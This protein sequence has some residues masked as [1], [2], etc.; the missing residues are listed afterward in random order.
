MASASPNPSWSDD[1]GQSDQYEDL[2]GLVL[3]RLSG[4]AN[5]LVEGVR[6]QPI[7]A[8]AIIA[9]GVGVLIGVGLARRHEDRA[10]EAREAVVEEVTRAGK[11][12]RKAGERG[13]RLVDYGELLP[14]AMK[15]WENPVVRGYVLRTATQ[16]VAKRF[17]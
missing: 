7:V 10:D 11:R 3:G 6:A 9:A 1:G 4:L 14:L 16:M 15:L 5:A 17:K 12:A 8:A 13:G 2:P